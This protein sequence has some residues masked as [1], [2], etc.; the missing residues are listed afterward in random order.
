MSL[1]EQD[2][3]KQGYIAQYKELRLNIVDAT[4]YATQQL[5]EDIKFNKIQ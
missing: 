3:I 5:I 4:R 2:K 1:I